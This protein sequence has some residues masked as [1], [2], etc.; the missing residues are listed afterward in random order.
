MS[1]SI[2]KNGIIS[3]ESFSEFIVNTFDKNF[4]VEPDGSMW[5]RIFHHNNPAN[6]RFD[7]S[8]SFTTQVYKDADRWFNVKL[9]DL[10]SGPYELIIKQKTTSDA[11]EVKYRWIQTTSPMGGDFE[12]TKA[13][14]IT[15]ITTSGYS[16][17]ANSGGIYLFNY[18]TYLVTN[19]GNNGN[20]HGAIGCWTIYQEGIPGYHNSIVTTGY[21]DLYLRIDD[22]VN[23]SKSTFGKNYIQCKD[24]IEF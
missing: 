12:S 5:I 13:A 17:I 22:K 20:W 4:Y 6:A 14:N 9:C 21:M 10:F 15:K 2:N 8:D 7:S 16:N 1:L 19:N 18:H 3:T 11:T 24:F 23:L